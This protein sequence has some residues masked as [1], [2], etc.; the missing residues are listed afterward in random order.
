MLKLSQVFLR[1]SIPIVTG[2]A[3][4]ATVSGACSLLIF[5]SYFTDGFIGIMSRGI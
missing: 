3:A 1:S 4:L 5:F 2:R